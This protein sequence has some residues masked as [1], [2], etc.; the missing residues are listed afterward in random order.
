MSLPYDRDLIDLA[1]DLRK[2]ATKQEQHLWYDFLRTYPV[3]FQRQKPVGGYIVDFY[4]HKARLV[5][6]LDGSQHFER[7]ALEYDQRR[8]AALEQVGLIVLRFTNR[9]IDRQFPG[10]CG[11]I[12]RVVQERLQK[13]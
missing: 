11:A 1:K 2:N 13:G 12:H 8:T 7:E 4:C 6:E 10:V 5:I 3:R 9:D